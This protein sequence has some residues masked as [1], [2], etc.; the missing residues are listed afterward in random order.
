MENAIFWQKAQNQRKETPLKIQFY[1]QDN[2]NLPIK[3]FSK[4]WKWQ[5][6]DFGPTFTHFYLLKNVNFK[7]ILSYVL[8]CNL[9]NFSRSM[10]SK[11]SFGIK[12]SWAIQWL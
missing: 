1:Y 5:P 3:T 9:V 7:S 6:F 4:A 12:I 8:C 11:V 10:E 2:I